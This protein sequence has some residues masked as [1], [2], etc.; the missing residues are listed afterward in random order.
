MR[1]VGDRMKKIYLFLSI[2]I[3]V[4]LSGCLYPQDKLTK[5]QIPNETQ[6]EVV[7][8][9]VNQYQEQTGGLVP[10]KT[11]PSDTPIF[12]KYIIDFNLLKEEGLLAE[13]PGNAFENGGHYQYALIDPENNAEVKLIDLRMTNILQDVYRKLTD[14]RSKNTYLPIIESIDDHFFM[15]DFERIGFEKDPYVTSP[16]SNDPLPIIMDSNGQLYVDYRGDLYNELE[17]IDIVTYENEDIRNILVDNSP[18]VP[19]Y[20]PNYTIEDGKPILAK[21]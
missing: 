5:N 4:I 21:D 6:M 7:Q 14:Y 10:I 18:F 8:V 11:K 16:F 15:I 17:D 19:I 9:A 12:E 13:I 20:S 3:I 2:C 1:K